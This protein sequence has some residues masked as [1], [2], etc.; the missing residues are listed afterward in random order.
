MID[1]NTIKGFATGAT[2]MFGVASVL[3]M[4]PEQMWRWINHDDS[5]DM[6]TERALMKPS[7]L[8]SRLEKEKSNLQD[9]LIRCEGDN[10]QNEKSLKSELRKERD[11]LE[12]KT[13]ALG[14]LEKKYNSA[15]LQ[16][17]K[18]AVP[19]PTQ[20]SLCAEKD[21]TSSEFAFDELVLEN[22][23][24]VILNNGTITITIT[25]TN[26]SVNMRSKTCK[27]KIMSFKDK[28]ENAEF[29]L[30]VTEP[31]PFKLKGVS[32]VMHATK[33]LHSPYRCF[34]KTFKL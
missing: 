26:L 21:T 7:A 8:L 19:R 10:N 23:K 30:S 17:Q 33:T 27:I 14:D 20:S 16:F 18:L 31:K 32:Y 24:P 25:I 2:V 28:S 34:V 3:L 1:K 11:L 22:K 15:Q 13:K 9:S 6:K 12:S 29:L 5:V 4:N